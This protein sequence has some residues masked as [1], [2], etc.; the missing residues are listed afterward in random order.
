MVKGKI[1]TNQTVARFT[2]RLGDLLL[3]FAN[4][5]ET[6]FQP[7]ATEFA[8]A[9]GAPPDPAAG[10][11]GF[12]QKQVLELPA[13]DSETGMRTAEIAAVINYD[14]PNVYNTLRSLQEREV[15]ELVAGT[16][17][18][19]WRLTGRF[20]SWH[21]GT[22][23]PYLRVAELVR[24]G[25]W[26]TY[27]DVSVAVRGDTKAA[28]AVGRAAAT[29]AHFPNPHRVLKEGGVIPDGWL[30]SDGQGPEECRSR[31]K[32]EGVKFVGDHASPNQRVAWDELLRRSE[33]PQ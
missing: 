12:R 20:G 11:W 33:K 22:S 4:E 7:E 18:Q 29:L 27:G 23:D 2:K 25:E 26:T 13:L 9:E 30:D 28:R 6:D 3:E 32:N 17:P 15:V 24:P 19:H 14:E 1:M 16:R 21:R 31:L 8:F 5:L 10:V